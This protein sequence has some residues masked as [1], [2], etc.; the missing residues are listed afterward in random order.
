MIKRYDLDKNWILRPVPGTILPEDLDIPEEGIEADI[1]GTVYTDLL[2]AG[3]IDDP[4]YA[5]NENRLQWIADADWLYETVFEIPDE[6]RKSRS[7]LLV[8][9]G[10]DT[11]AD[12]YLN[13]ERLGRTA[14]MF[15]RISFEI[16]N[17]IRPAENILKI[18]FTSARLYARKIQRPIHQFPSARNTERVFVRKAQYS[19]GW[20]WGPAFPTAGIWRPAYILGCDRIRIDTVRTD[21]LSVGG[22]TAKVRIK[23]AVTGTTQPGD[24]IR[25]SLANVKHEFS[26]EKHLTADQV[27]DINLKVTDPDLWWPNGLGEPNL[28]QLGILLTDRKGN[29]LDRRMYKTGIRTIRLQLEDDAKETFRFLVNDQ[30]VFA[31]GANWIP[32]DSF[33]SRVKEK[34]YR[35]LLTLARDA[36]MNMIR[37]WG[38][39]VYEA[40]VFYEI[41]D[42]LGLMIWQDFMFACAA[43]PDDEKFLAEILSEIEQNIYRLQHHPALVIWCGNN[44]NEWI[45]YRDDCGDQKDMPGFTIFHELIPAILKN[46]DPLR[47][48]RPTTPFGEE[49]DPNDFA[50]GNRHAWDIWSYW[51]DYT[52]VVKDN[53]HFVTEF[54]FQAP[55]AFSTLAGAIPDPELRPHARLFEFHNKQEEGAE[56]LT[57]FLAGHLPLTTEIERYIYLTQLNQGLALKT[58]LEHWRLNWPVTNGSI[59]W[60]LNDCWPVTSWALID[61]SGLPKLAYYFVRRAF[62]SHMVAFRKHNREL[63][64]FLSNQNFRACNGYIQLDEVSVENGHIL[65]REKLDVAVKK[66]RNECLKSFLINDSLAQGRHILVATLYDEA[67]QQ[68]N[69]NFYFASRWKYIRLPDPDIRFWSMPGRN[70][71]VMLRSDNAVVFFAALIHPDLRFDENGIILMPGEPYPVSVSGNMS[72]PDQINKIKIFT[73]NQFLSA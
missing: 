62:H 55:A 16:D 57:R 47:P 56:R 15:R 19:S 6:V 9:D 51:V 50:S 5:D 59:V 71:Q 68:I 63:A 3:L 65:N 69:R 2:N 58:C 27:Y 37:V 54:G 28:Y 33:L 8:F 60:Q 46:L 36:N 38:G 23:V 12:I 43:Y 21:T 11:V 17:K 22:K 39:G 14:N 45:W 72:G 35:F 10:L 70:D 29:I 26:E 42:E 53:S 48:Y 66:Q 25:V 49:P 61:Y 41:C 1:P 4:F 32:A 67:D 7:I 31:K 34:D 40:D 64:L 30:V 73:L 52:E 24:K 18:Q 20:D 13:G 44:E